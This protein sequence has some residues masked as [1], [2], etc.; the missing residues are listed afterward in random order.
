MSKFN[1]RFGPGREDPATR[2]R[3]YCLIHYPTAGKG[4]HGANDTTLARA[5]DSGAGG[6]GDAR[7]DDHREGGGSTPTPALLDI[8]VRPIPHRI[9]TQILVARHY[10][11]SMPGGTKLSFGVFLG[12]RL[13]GVLT[14]GSGPARSYRLV[15]GATP[16]DCLT[17]TR[18]WLSD[19]LPNNSESRVIG[20]V[21]RAM[22]MHSSV[23]FLLSYADPAAG[24]IGT[25]YQATNW[26]YTGPSV[27]IPKYDIG[28]GVLHHSRSL[29]YIC[30]THSVRYFRAKGV[31]VR[32]VPQNPKH[33]Y[34]YFLD[35]SWQDGLKVPILPYPKKEE[36]T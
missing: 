7:P 3:V 15:R 29:S 12:S 9:A 8:V 24:H 14:L 34:I 26:L 11:G 19:Q 5:A 4:L 6:V 23:K 13:L 30:G 28:D 10:L 20:I 25:I 2:D 16:E 32:T 18:L 21:L 22:R 31:H 27:A 1:R 35:P 33:R 17:L 36:S